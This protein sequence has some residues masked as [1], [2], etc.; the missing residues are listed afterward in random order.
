MD[1]DTVLLDNNPEFYHSGEAVRKTRSLAA[2]DGRARSAA[3]AA[4]V[5]VD[6]AVEAEAERRGC[7]LSPSLKFGLSQGV[8][9]GVVY[10]FEADLKANTV[11]VQLRSALRSSPSEVLVLTLPPSLPVGDCRPVALLWA[12]CTVIE[13]PVE[14]EFPRFTSD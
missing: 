13:M 4:V 11:R 5:T 2:G 9:S 10:T 8:D 12:S 3:S 6:A 1:A 14:G 7:A